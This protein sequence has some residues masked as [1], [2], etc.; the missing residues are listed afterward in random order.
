MSELVLVSRNRCYQARYH[1]NA[2]EL[3]AEQNR[4]R[5][6]EQIDRVLLEVGEELVG[7]ALC[8][9]RILLTTI[10]L[11]PGLD[12]VRRRC[13]ATI[14]VRRDAQHG[15]ARRIRARRLRSRAVQR[16]KVG[17]ECLR[18]RCLDRPIGDQ[19]HD[20]CG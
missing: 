14:E 6:D 19:E 9:G 12:V 7:T 10:R 15:R 5:N 18:E 17:R 16:L 4:R 1:G 8:R 13:A 2:Y 11:S 20:E 3:D